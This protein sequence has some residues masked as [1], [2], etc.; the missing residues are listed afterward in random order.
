MNSIER[1][2]RRRRLPGV[3]LPAWGSTDFFFMSVFE[4]VETPGTNRVRD[5]EGYDGMAHMTNHLWIGSLIY[6]FS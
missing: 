6:N 4:F 2:T 5:P 1:A 3:P